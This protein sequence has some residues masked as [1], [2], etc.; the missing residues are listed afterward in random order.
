MRLK[1]KVE[2]AVVVASLSSTHFF[3]CWYL[4]SWVNI[5]GLGDQGGLDC[6]S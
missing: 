1:I 4:V 5:F 6:S 2:V 3:Y